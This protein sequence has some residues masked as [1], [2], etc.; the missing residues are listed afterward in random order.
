[1]GVTS[2]YS[3]PS[4]YRNCLSSACG[5]CDASALRAEEAKPPLCTE[6]AMIV[7]V[8]GSSRMINARKYS[9]ALRSDLSSAVAG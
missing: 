3:R 5:L 9:Q 6:D 8:R 7:F 1:M 2:I 4:T